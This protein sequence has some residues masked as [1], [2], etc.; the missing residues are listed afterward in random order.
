MPQCFMIMTRISVTN[1]VSHALKEIGVQIPDPEQIE[2]L[3]VSRVREHLQDAGGAKRDLSPDVIAGLI[4]LLLLR[5]RTCV[6]G[7]DGTWFDQH[8]GQTIGDLIDYLEENQLSL[9]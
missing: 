9:D 5:W 3:T 2:A 1:C 4:V 8:G 7:F 6:P